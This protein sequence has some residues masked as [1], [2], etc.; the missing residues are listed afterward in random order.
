MMTAAGSFQP[1]QRLVKDD[2]FLAQPYPACLSPACLSLDQDDTASLS[3]HSSI[4]TQQEHKSVSPCLSPVI[5]PT[6]FLSNNEPLFD[7]IEDQLLPDTFLDSIDCDENNKN[8]EKKKAKRPLEDEEDHPTSDAPS[9]QKHR[10][11]TKACSTFRYRKTVQKKKSKQV[12]DTTC[13]NSNN[14]SAH[15]PCQLI[16]KEEESDTTLF[17]HLTES[18]IDWCRYCGTTEGVNWRPG[19]WG[20]RTLCNKHG[21]DYKGYG[22]ASRQP[23]LDLSAF[24]N[25]ALSDRIKPVIQQFCIVCQSPQEQEGDH[26]IVCGGGCSRAYHQQCHTPVINMNRSDPVRWYCSALCKENRKRNKVVVE[27]PRKHMPLLHLLKK[28][29]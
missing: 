1:I 29:N 24:I 26:L 20:K 11:K 19:P 25:E 12:D 10:K 9:R 15:T 5:S 21:C 6:Q 3:S 18:G 22:L 16:E 27:L 17:Q 4:S 13:N 28:G 23:R 14:S 8:D 7:G 2:V